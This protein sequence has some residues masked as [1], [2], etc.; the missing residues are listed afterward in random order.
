MRLSRRNDVSSVPSSA[1][2]CKRRLQSAGFD[3][4]Q[5]AC[6]QADRI[7]GGP[8]VE[9]SRQKLSVACFQAGPAARNQDIFAG[10]D[11]DLG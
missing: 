6:F 7:G 11:L 1:P 10:A 8:G 9:A 4:R 3:R 2:T 5:V